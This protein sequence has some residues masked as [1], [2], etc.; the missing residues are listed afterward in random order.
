M[1]KKKIKYA[2]FI[3]M[4]IICVS[5]VFPTPV[6]AKKDSKGNGISVGASKVI[7]TPD[8]TYISDEGVKDDLYARCMIIEWKGK[9][10]IMVTLDVQNHGFTDINVPIAAKVEA[11]YGINT[12][13]LLIGSTHNHGCT[14][15]IIGVYFGNANPYIVNVYKP[16]VIDKVVDA[17]GEALNDMRRAT[18]YVGSIWVEGLTFNRRSYPD[19]GPTDDELTVLKFVDGEGETIA[20]LVNFATH[21][22]VTMTGYLASADF[23]GFLCEKLEQDHGGIGVYFNGAQGNIN[24]NM[25]IKYDSPWGRY[26]EA[27]YAAAL[28]YGHDIAE[29]ANLALENAKVFKNLPLQ[30][31]QI[32]LEIPIENAGFIYLMTHGLLLRE[33]YQDEEGYKLTTYVSGVKMGPIEM[34]T[35]PGELFSEIALYV[36]S[37]MP[38]YGFLLG[39]TPEQLGYI[40]PQDQWAPNS[41]EVGESNSMGYQTA[42]LITEALLEVVQALN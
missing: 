42:P 13:Y 39:L 8:T 26:D 36:K 28:E 34:V 31:V 10:I 12:D 38:K 3:S 29:W 18:V 41:G 1:V 23:C 4:V 30:T 24:P 20:T 11:K 17:I 25:Y 22:V 21:P 2:I 33:Y 7:I 32:S 6:F 15:D 37:Y 35:V 16:M 19:P 27:Q 9:F 5:M 14:V 40:I